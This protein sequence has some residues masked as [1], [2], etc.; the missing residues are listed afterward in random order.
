MSSFFPSADGKMKWCTAKY[1]LA[2]RGGGV[3]PQRHI[4][5]DS[6]GTREVLAYLINRRLS[7]LRT[8]ADEIISSG[9]T[10]VEVLM[11]ILTL[12]SKKVRGK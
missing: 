5:N 7:P 8:R 4:S 12:S 11:L 1:K 6:G 10:M 3:S 9:S 2:N